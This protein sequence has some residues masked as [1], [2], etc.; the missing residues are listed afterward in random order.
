MADK[1][2]PED[3]ISKQ[4]LWEKIDHN[5]EIAE[6]HK[7]EILFQLQATKES[8]RTDT[9][10]LNNEHSLLMHKRLGEVENW[11]RAFKLEVQRDNAEAIKQID[12]LFKNHL[13][14]V[15]LRLKEFRESIDTAVESGAATLFSS[16]EERITVVEQKFEELSKGQNESLSK[17]QVETRTKM[18]ELR[19]K[20]DKV[21]SK[22]RDGFTDL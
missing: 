22:L 1:I 6:S 20:I 9:A 2:P 16:N 21:I 18:G 3:E 19:S 10:H 15:E 12:T 17:Y 8:L 13:G 7:G 5:R 11:L 14:E 4:Y